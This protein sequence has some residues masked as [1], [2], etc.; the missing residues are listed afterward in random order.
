MPR[1]N[2]RLSGRSAALLLLVVCLAACASTSP[3]EHVGAN[4]A[5]KRLPGKGARQHPFVYAGQWDTRKPDEQSVFIVREGRIVWQYSMPLKTAQGRIQEFSDV[6]LLPDGNL[7]VAHMSGAAL[8]SPGKQIL[9]AYPADAGSE[10]HSIQSLGDTRVLIMRN[11]SPAKATIIDTATNHL[12]SETIIPTEVTVPHGQFRHVRMTSSGTLLVPH[13]GEGKVV[14]YDLTGREVWRVEAGSP[15]QAI[16]TREGNTLIAGDKHRYVREVNPAGE[17]VWEFS[18]ADA[19]GYLLGNIQTASRLEN[20]NTVM[21][22]WIAGEKDASRWPGT[23]QVLEVTRS[24]KIVWALS[25]W[26][27]PDLGPATSIQLLDDR[28]PIHLQE[29]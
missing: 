29:R 16:R 3:N 13:L 17:V 5:P 27:D 9:W 23:V 8:I 21:C 22:L 15:W 14:E 11:G 1:W 20:G 24:K 10:I 25:S 26:T 28:R 19:P 7:L 18:S 2:G 12:E 4:G 6:T